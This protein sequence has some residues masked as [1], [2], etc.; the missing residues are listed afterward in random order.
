MLAARG[1]LQRLLRYAPSLMLILAATDILFSSYLA[2]EISVTRIYAQT[3]PRLAAAS[4]SN[5]VSQERRVHLLVGPSRK[6][7]CIATSTVSITAAEPERLFLEEHY[8]IGQCFRALKRTP[9][10]TLHTVDSSVAANGRRELRRTYTLETDGLRCDIEEIFPDRD[11]FD[12]GEHWLKPVSQRPARV[13]LGGLT[14][15]HVAY[16]RPPSPTLT[17]ASSPFKM[18]YVLWS[19]FFPQQSVKLS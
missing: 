14:P 2:T 1:D 16:S 4:P 5:P 6:L 7:A 15:T 10:F 13:T 8:A 19:Y 9:V 3:S 11:M 18:L 12:L 17:T